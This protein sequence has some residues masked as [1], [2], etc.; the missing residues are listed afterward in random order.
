MVRDPVTQ[1]WLTRPITTNL[2]GVEIYEECGCPWI[3]LKKKF[4]IR[5]IVVVVVLVA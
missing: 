1:C 4:C 2:Q 5:D 3:F